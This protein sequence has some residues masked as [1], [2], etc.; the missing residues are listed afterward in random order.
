MDLLYIQVDNRFSLTYTESV[1]LVLGIYCDNNPISVSCVA[2]DLLE[3]TDNVAMISTKNFGLM[4][5]KKMS[6]KR[7]LI[8]ERFAERFTFPQ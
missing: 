6:Q 3:E 4:V 8:K 7:T 2:S 1:G 5:R